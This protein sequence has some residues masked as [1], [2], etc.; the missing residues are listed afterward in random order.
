MA[1][2]SSVVEAQLKA[3]GKLD[4]FGTKKEIRELPKIMA[5]GETILGMASGMMDGTP[6]SSR[7]RTAGSSSWTRACS[8]ASSSWSC[9]W[10]GSSP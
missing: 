10:P 8:T 4:T 6:G 3:L 7:S 2:D 5:Q 1:V 9:P